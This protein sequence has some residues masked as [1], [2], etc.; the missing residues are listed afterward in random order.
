MTSMQADPTDTIALFENFDEITN[1]FLQLV[2]SCDEEELNTVPYKGS[3]TVAQVAE[4]VTRS[5]ITIIQSMQI[6]GKKSTRELDERVPELKATFLD[7]TIKLNSPGFI[8]PTKATYQKDP[9]VSD[10][11]RS[12]KRLREVSEKADFSEALNHPIFEEITKLEI[13]HFV[14]Y[15]TQRHI[16]QLKKV[17][18]S[19]KGKKSK[20]FGTF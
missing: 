6:E 8:L 16:Q 4:H 7:F 13:F 11:E 3:W 15:H 10:L 2:R 12:I 5:N 9:L 1:E 14:L 20:G 19:V 18:S 17:I